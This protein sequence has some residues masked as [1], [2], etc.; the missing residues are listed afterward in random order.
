M[1]V[2]VPDHDGLR[3]MIG[4]CGGAIAA[5]SANISGMP[6]AQNA[7]EAAAY[8]GDSVDLIVDGG[9]ARGGV[10]STVVDCLRQSPALLRRGAIGEEEIMRVYGEVVG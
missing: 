5:T 8:L 2:R 6:D 10:P 4:L 9:P 1:A 7:H 3:Y